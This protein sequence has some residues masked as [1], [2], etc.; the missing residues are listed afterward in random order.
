MM[1]IAP[2]SPPHTRNLHAA[3]NKII[4]LVLENEPVFP[5]L[6]WRFVHCAFSRRASL[7]LS[8]RRIL[9]SETLVKGLAYPFLCV[10]LAKVLLTHHGKARFCSYAKLWAGKIATPEIEVSWRR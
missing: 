4:V 8:Q 3:E 2:V 7:R 9:F 1:L 10:E 5:V 6:S